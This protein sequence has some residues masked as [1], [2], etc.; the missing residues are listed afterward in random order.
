MEQPKSVINIAEKFPQDLQ[1]CLVLLD[2]RFCFQAWDLLKL[3]LHSTFHILRS[4]KLVGKDSVFLRG[5]PPCSS[6]YEHQKLDCFLPPPPP[7]FLILCIILLLLLGEGFIRGDSGPRMTGPWVWSGNM[8]WNSKIMNKIL[9][10][11]KKRLIPSCFSQY[12]VSQ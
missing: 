6:E 2:L 10:K 11:N 4:E 1:S 12:G 5:R 7:P 8:K 3:Q 9:C